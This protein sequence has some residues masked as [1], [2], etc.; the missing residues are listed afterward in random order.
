MIKLS[1]NNQSC[2]A[3][4]GFVNID[5]HETLFYPLTANVNKFGASSNSIDYLYARVCVPN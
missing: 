4:S 3:E 1:L 5:S 2:Q